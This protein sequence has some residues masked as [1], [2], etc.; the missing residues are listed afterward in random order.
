MPNY[1][2]E[3]HGG[4]WGYTFDQLNKMFCEVIEKHS[5]NKKVTLLIHDW[6]SKNGLHL[7]MSH[8]ELVTR[9]DALDV[10]GEMPSG[11][12]FKIFAWSY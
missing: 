12:G 3:D 8:P 9:I 6:G 1:G 7:A 10:A 4:H 2:P 11:T 5:K